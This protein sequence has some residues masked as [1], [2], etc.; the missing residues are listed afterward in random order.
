M[1]YTPVEHTGTG[2]GN[3]IAIS[4][5]LL[6]LVCGKVE[7]FALMLQSSLQSSP[8]ILHCSALLSIYCSSKL[9][10]LRCLEYY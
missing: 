2:F 5:S 1:Q 10:C 3:W 7:E 4:M 8:D 6:P 9:Q